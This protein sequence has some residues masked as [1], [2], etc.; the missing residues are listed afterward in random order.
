MKILSILIIVV[1]IVAVMSGTICCALSRTIPHISTA[2]FV[3]LLSVGIALICFGVTCFFLGH[4]IIF[5]NWTKR[6]KK[7]IAKES[8]KYSSRLP[9]PCTW[10]LDVSKDSIGPNA[11]GGDQAFYQVSFI[12]FLRLER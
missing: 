4:Y 11:V 2:A 6:L 7:A 8:V 3:I 10:R 1:S 12:Y 9:I 5:V